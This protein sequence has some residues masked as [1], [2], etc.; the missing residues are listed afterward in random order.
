MRTKRQAAFTLVELLTVIAIIAVL[1]A[2]TVGG[3]KFA[4]R[5]SAEN[6]AKAEIHALE[7]ALG[8]YK[9]DNGFYPLQSTYP[10]PAGS[11]TI[12]Y[13][14]LVGGGRKYFNF[15]PDELQSVGA[16]KRIIDP[17][18]HEYLYLCPGTHN[19]ATFDLWSAGPDGLSTTSANQADDVTNWQSN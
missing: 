11:S 6:R 10:P 8:D 14:A 2:L 3:A 17:F 18:G 16:A 5:K 15:K 4:L 13:N 1:A 12:I 9:A 7:A 19:P